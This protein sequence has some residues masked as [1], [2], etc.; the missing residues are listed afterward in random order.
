MSRRTVGFVTVVV[1]VTALVALMAWALVQSGGNPGGLGI[2]DAFGEVSISRGPAPPLALSLLDGGNIE[3]A[4]LKG[5]VV[6]VDFWSS[7]C[8]PCI[9]EAPDLAATYR[10]YQGRQVE[11]LGIAIWDEDREVNRYVERFGIGYPNAIDA[12]GRVAINYGVRGIPEKY[13]IDRDGQLL[14][15]VVG[16]VSAE[17]LRTI[18]DE[19]LSQQG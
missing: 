18:I 15:K 7:W 9:A 2:N 8:P 13:F 14:R 3:L 1:P 19:L 17:E 12:R 10:E 11:F 6:M 16:P 5:K 4:D